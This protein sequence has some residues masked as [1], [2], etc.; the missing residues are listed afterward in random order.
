M[1]STASHCIAAIYYLL[2]TLVT[3]FSH[4][5]LYCS[6]STQNNDLNW[7]IHPLV[8]NN[9]CQL[10]GLST[11]SLKTL[12]HPH[13]NSPPSDLRT[14]TLTQYNIPNEIQAALQIFPLIWY[15]SLASQFTDFLNWIPTVDFIGNSFPFSFFLWIRTLSQSVCLLSYHKNLSMTYSVSQSPLTCT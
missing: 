2:F 4:W 15:L 10:L 3:I 11:V 14:L 5:D 13:P 1:S 7:F 9:G 8:L 6:H 12:T